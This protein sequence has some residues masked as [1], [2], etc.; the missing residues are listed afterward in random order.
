LRWATF[1]ALSVFFV[2]QACVYWQAVIDDSYITFRFVDMFAKGHGWRFNPDGPRVEGF[3]N[4]LWAVLLVP[5]HLLGWDL[6]YVSKILGLASGIA[7]MLATWG[8][9][10]AIRRRDDWFNLIGPALLASNSHFAHWAMMGLETLLQVALVAGAYWRFEVERRDLRAWPLSAVLALLAALTRVDS[11]YYLSPLGLYAILLAMNRLYPLRRMMV[12]ALITA[13]PFGV[14]TGW[15]WVYFGSLAP[16]TYWAKQRHIVFEG[17]GRG[18]EQLKRYYFHQT[19]DE[20]RDP[21]PWSSIDPK[22]EDAVRERLLR[23][24]WW[25]ARGDW[26]TW[27]W[28]N[29]WL[30]AA[31]GSLQ[32][33]LAWWLFPSRSPRDRWRRWR[34]D[35]PATVACLILIPWALN[36]YYVHHTN[37]DWMPGF[38]FF[39]NV[40]PFIGVGFAVTAGW[41]AALASGMVLWKAIATRVITSVVAG[42]LLFS[43]IYEQMHIATIYIFGR[44]SFIYIQREPLWATKAGVQNAWSKGFAPPLREVSEQLLLVTPDNASIFMSDI[45]QPLWFAEHLS[46]YDVDGLVDPHLAH[47]PQVRGDIPALDHFKQQILGDRDPSSLDR[48][49]REWIENEARKQEFEAHVQ[50]NARWI[51]QEKRP[52]FLLLFINHASPD[53]R[54]PGHVYPRVSEVVHQQPEM[55]NYEEI[56]TSPKVGNAYNHLYRRRDVTEAPDARTRLQRVMGAMDRNPRMPSLAVLLMREANQVADISEQENEE[57]TRRILRMIR[58]FPGD[59][60]VGEIA[61]RAS[62]SGR[63]NFAIEALETVISRAPTNPQAYRSLSQIHERKSDFA[64]AAEVLRRGIRNGAARDNWMYYHLAWC[65]EMNRQVEAALEVIREAI[66]R[67]PNDLRAWSDLGA[68]S[69]RGAMAESENK[70]LR[71]KRLEEARLGLTRYGELLGEVPAHIREQLRQIELQLAELAEE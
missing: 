23:A 29:L 69:L 54:S 8:L 5:P 33:A 14:Y 10:A 65:L 13:V 9:A 60:A 26:R 21:A 66:S 20:R 35:F 46:L 62:L 28:M 32:V 6:M 42:W 59:P 41:F 2:V 71:R 57:V 11:L 52:E 68:I 1:V 40:L 38:R 25:T 56:W 48:R 44:D 22:R 19:G 70:P 61:S 63:E 16:N 45:G 27:G 39:Q 55:E 31:L 36:V 15:R 7:A 64:R 51:M 12:W 34:T 58:R 37:G 50:R 43:T 53:P 4:F 18:A 24:A 47:A 30:I 49:T 67:Q 3:T 17:R